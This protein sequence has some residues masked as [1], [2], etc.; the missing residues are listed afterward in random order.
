MMSSTVRGV[1]IAAD[2]RAFVAAIL[3]GHD[4]ARKE[5]DD[6]AGDVVAALDS[7][8]AC[9]MAVRTLPCGPILSITFLRD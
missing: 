3:V 9:V 5:A 2:P 6:L 4:V 1:R 8:G 7:A